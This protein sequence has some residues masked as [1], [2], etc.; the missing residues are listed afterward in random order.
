MGPKVVRPQQVPVKIPNKKLSLIYTSGACLPEPICTDL[1][2]LHQIVVS[3]P[4]GRPKR[5]TARLVVSAEYPGVLLGSR[6]NSGDQ[7]SKLKGKH[8]NITC[9]SLL[10][11]PTQRG[12]LAFKTCISP[13]L[14]CITYDAWK[15]NPIILRV[16]SPSFHRWICYRT[17]QNLPMDFHSY[18]KTAKQS[19]WQ[20]YWENLSKEAFPPMW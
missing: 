16:P 5:R 2:M 6:T 20:K 10:L 3:M 19:D 1:E 9:N 4:L 7:G 18:R 15:F 8:I 13:G 12:I 17:S 11:G 14:T